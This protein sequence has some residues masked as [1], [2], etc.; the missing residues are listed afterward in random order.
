M[1]IYKITLLLLFTLTNLQAQYIGW[2][3]IDET[4]V[5]PWQADFE[6]DYA[7]SY[8]FGESEGESTLNLIC[9][10]GFWVGQIAS[11]EFS[12]DGR[13]WIPKYVNLKNIKINP[14]GDFKSDSYSGSFVSYTNENGTVENGLKINNSWSGHEK[15]S[16]EIGIRT[17]TNFDELYNGDYKEASYKVLFLDD[18]KTLPKEKLQIMRNEIFGR[19]GYIFKK[20]GN[21]EKH[22][23]Q[24]KWYRPIHKNVDVYLTAIEKE[25]VKRI[26]AAEKA[27]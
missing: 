5:R 13:A 8:H 20:S 6:S 25:N 2:S 11:G 10:E 19:Y 16:Y 26:A 12:D 14:E 17:M 24:Q 27:K 22:F 1:R 7:G 18:L 9:S 4:K 21:M 15:G 23:K 3:E